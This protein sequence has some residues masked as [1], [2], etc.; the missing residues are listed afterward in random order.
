MYDV[1]TSITEMVHRDYFKLLYD[2]Q[3]I[4]YKDIAQKIEEY[5]VVLRLMLEGHQKVGMFYSVSFIKDL[6]ALS[7]LTKKRFC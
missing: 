5:D 2:A 6:E 1:T 3:V 4:S 7:L